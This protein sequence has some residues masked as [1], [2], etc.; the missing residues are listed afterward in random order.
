MLSS[1]LCLSHFDDFSTMDSANSYRFQSSQKL[2]TMLTFGD[3]ITVHLTHHWHHWLFSAHPL[4]MKPSL[5]GFILW[6]WLTTWTWFILALLLE[7]PA[8]LSGVQT[9]VIMIFWWSNYPFAHTVVKWIDDTPP[10]SS[11]SFQMHCKKGMV[12][13]LSCCL[14]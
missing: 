9:K 5:W 2:A 6:G 4:C 11:S 14:Q 7:T 8:A 10:T 12:A 3:F 1:F 13:I